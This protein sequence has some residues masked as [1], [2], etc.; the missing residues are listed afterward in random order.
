VREVMKGSGICVHVRMTG[1]TE[2]MLETVKK[3]LHPDL[4]LVIH[5]AFIDLPTAQRNYGELE[6]LLSGYYKTHQN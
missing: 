4:K 3:V 6:Q 5:P 1:E 2:R